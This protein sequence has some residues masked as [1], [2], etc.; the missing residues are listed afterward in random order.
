MKG[1][2]ALE[3]IINR[4]LDVHV[5]FL[6]ENDIILEMGVNNAAGCDFQFQV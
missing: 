2:V 3:D 1:F 4:F 5:F 6:M